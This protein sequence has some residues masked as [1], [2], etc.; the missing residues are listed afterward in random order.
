MNRP[1]IYRRRVTYDGDIVWVPLSVM[2]AEYNKAISTMTNWCITGFWIERGYRLR[3]ECRGQWRVGVP[4]SE[5][6]Q[7]SQERIANLI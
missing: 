1:P 7:F 5:Y 4:Q 3:K 6:A 2:A